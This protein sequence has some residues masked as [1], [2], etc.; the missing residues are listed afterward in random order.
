MSVSCMRLNPFIFRLVTSFVIILFISFEAGASISYLQLTD[1][2]QDLSPYIQIF[3]D[4][5]SAI[6]SEQILSYT[7]QFTDNSQ[8]QVQLD[9][10][11]STY[12]LRIDITNPVNEI[13]SRV[14]D[15]DYS[16]IPRTK[17]YKVN[18]NTLQ[19][20][21]SIDL[22]KSVLSRD[23]IFRNPAFHIQ[24]APYQKSSF[25]IK[26]TVAGKANHKLEL[27][28]HLYSLGSFILHQSTLHILFAAFLGFLL[29]LAIYNLI[30]FIKVEVSGYIYYSLYSICIMSLVL[31]YE[32]FIFYLPISFP[33][34]WVLNGL[35]LIPIYTSICFMA[36]G[37]SVLQLSTF[38]IKVDTFYK[39]H[40]LALLLLSPATL[41]GIGPVNLI[42]ELSAVIATFTLGLIAIYLY[43]RGNRA[44]KFF[45]ISFIFIALGYM[46]ETFLYSIPL[47]S[48]FDNA[49][50]SIVIGITEQ[51]FFY[52]CAA[53]D[54]I[55]LAFALSSYINQMRA[56]KTKAQ[57]LAMEQLHET[58]IIKSNYANELELE[59]A[60]RTQQITAQSKK[61][62]DQNTKLKQLD[63]LKSDFFANISHEFR[64]PL[65][66]IRGPFQ[67]M[68]NGSYGQLNDQLIDAVKIGSQNTDRLSRLIEELLT[69]SKLESGALKLRVC[70]QD[71]CGFSRR[72]V[73]LFKHTAEEKSI[74]FTI[75]IPD[76]ISNFYFDTDKVETVLCN[77]LSN[78]FKYTQPTG[79]VEFIVNIPENMDQDIENYL[80]IIIRDNGP[81]IP[82]ELHNKVF[83]R[84]YRMDS[85]E[86]TV[87]QGSGIG[88]ALVKE[89][90]ELHGG[91]V[92]LKESKS[93]GCEFTVMLP[94]G[95]A[96]F[97]ADE[98]TTAGP[99][100]KPLT[101]LADIIPIS[102]DQIEYK[103]HSNEKQTL[104]LVE[105]TSDMRLF[106]RSLFSDEFNIIEAENGKT[107]LDIL[108]REA[109]DI[110][111][112][113]IMMPVM[114]GITMLEHIRQNTS[115]EYLPVLLLT[116]R[117]AD[118]DRI[119]A[120]KAK[121]D[122]YLAKPFDA[123]ELKL[124]V[125]NLLYRTNSTQVPSIEVKNN[126]NKA[127]L[128]DSASQQFLD[129][130]K[131]LI[132]D[133]ISDSKFGVIQL[134]EKLFVSRNT[135]HRRFHE[136]CNDSPAN[137][138]RSVR[139]EQA[140]VLSVN[141]VYRT[142]A[143]LAYAVGFNN[144]SY[145]SKIYNKYKSELNN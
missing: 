13:Q 6:T 1:K 115:T 140:H 100:I 60:D 7:D 132:L 83:E 128:I 33:V 31:F 109:I 139:L 59:I 145:F 133:N 65:T 18:N 112:S 21:D 45:S 113:D 77:L 50:A 58:N 91:K 44:A 2:K 129:K 63:K 10:D 110:V 119:I 57:Q 103:I 81:G 78:A 11:Q 37:R 29:S 8:N 49:T 122:D 25:L 116:A 136:S 47:M 97:M 55:F 20:L 72:I 26:L 36:F 34:E 79:L 3:K 75:D 102:T 28:P 94:T 90:V 41:I 131:Q 68:I 17:L 106:I 38:N 138:M 22:D 19:L 67:Q 9:I 71:I 89:L 95:S 117:A 61:L 27:R 135:L 32:G 93:S 85:S 82:T 23:I 54:M 39:Y 76:T 120:L 101:P 53:L 73:S 84:F 35:N 92:D 125:R 111:V 105:D 108:K 142:K 15:L 5:S 14:I 24:L 12:W 124:R 130:A 46:I 127:P 43:T 48:V 134:A 40:L 88:L 66:L 121:A 141:N 98:L 52:T 114:D 87:I 123:E 51:Y 104:L 118:E 74:T 86:S 16:L 70:E 80:S 137:F 69:L 56:E 64:T 126:E 107:A 99:H 144:P 143:E 42:L 4:T 30:L 96:H 62:Q